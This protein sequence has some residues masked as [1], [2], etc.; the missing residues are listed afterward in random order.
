[1]VGPWRHTRRGGLQEVAVGDAEEQGAGEELV[2]TEG[3]H[4]PGTWAGRVSRRGGKQDQQDQE[5]SGSR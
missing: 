4:W 1:M 2:D 5:R 3:E